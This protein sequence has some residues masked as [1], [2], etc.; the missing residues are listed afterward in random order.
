MRGGGE[1]ISCSLGIGQFLD[2]GLQRVNAPRS[3][4]TG[5]LQ[6]SP[7][8]KGW[9]GRGGRFTSK[10]CLKYESLR[11]EYAA[12]SHLTAGKLTPSSR[13][14]GRARSFQGDVTRH[15]SCPAPRAPPRWLCARKPSVRNHLD[16]CTRTLKYL[17]FF[18]LFKENTRLQRILIPTSARAAAHAALDVFTMFVQ[19]C[20]SWCRFIKVSDT[21]RA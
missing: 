2:N 12:S 20:S 18:F 17:F 14:E 19:L 9:R 10:P 1:L 6:G 13:Q 5:G 11:S 8:M 3:E 7:P 4:V 15:A 21:S 16:S